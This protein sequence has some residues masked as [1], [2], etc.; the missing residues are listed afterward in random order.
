MKKYKFNGRPLTTLKFLELL[1]RYILFNERVCDIYDM[2][3]NKCGETTYR[4][5]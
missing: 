2:N 3:G 4:E 5:F 1:A